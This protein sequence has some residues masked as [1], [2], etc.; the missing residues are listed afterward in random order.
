MYEPP[1]SLPEFSAGAS[2]FQ[3]PKTAKTESR[4]KIFILPIISYSTLE[5]EEFT[6]EKIHQKR[7]RDFYDHGQGSHHPQAV[8]QKFHDQKR[9]RRRQ[10]RR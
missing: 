2:F 1:S 10:R 9:N 4:R 5:Y 3:N 7:N 8:D 6:Y